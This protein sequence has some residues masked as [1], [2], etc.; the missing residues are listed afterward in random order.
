MAPPRRAGTLALVLG[1][2]LN[3]ASPVLAGLD[4]TQD[5]VLMVEAPEESTHVWSHKARIALFLAAMRH[6]AEDL[7]RDGVPLDYLAIGTH[8]HA[9]LGDAWREEIAARRPARVRCVEPGDW[10]VLEMLQRVCGEAGVALE[11]VPDPHFLCTRADF[12]HWAGDRST[13]RMEFFY[14]GCGGARAC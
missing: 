13:L 4:R 3:R 11:V 5:M 1:D 8:A 9:S 2:Q 6:Y 10:R 14:G 7:R 12:E